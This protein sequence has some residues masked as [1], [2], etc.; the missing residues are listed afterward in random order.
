MAALTD[1]P[2]A[3]ALRLTP[4]VAAP[5][6]SAAEDAVSDTVSDTFPATEVATSDAPVE[7]DTAGF[8]AFDS[9]QA[10]LTGSSRKPVP[11]RLARRRADFS[12]AMCPPY[13]R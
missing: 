11:A 12:L 2:A 6:V 13:A 9:S 1:R 7:A 10:V 8:S 4:A 5:A 3:L